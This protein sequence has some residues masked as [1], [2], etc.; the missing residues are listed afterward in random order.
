MQVPSKDT[1]TVVATLSRQVGRLPATLRR[2]LIWDRRLEM[3]QHRSFTIRKSVSA[4][5]PASVS[6]QRSVVACCEWQGKD[7]AG[8]R[9][10]LG[11]TGYRSLW[12][13][14]FVGCYSFN[15]SAATRAATPASRD[16]GAPRAARDADRSGDYTD[17]APSSPRAIASVGGAYFTRV[18][19]LGK[20]WGTRLRFG[21]N[22]SGGLRGCYV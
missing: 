5:S 16:R 22:S 2:S 4:T 10:Y 6:P 3:A 9:K 7:E 14:H 15:A 21:K 17:Y 13:R 8:F 11:G 12:K 18:N 20:S 19:W 1:A